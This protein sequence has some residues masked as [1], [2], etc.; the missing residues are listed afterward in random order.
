MS[1]ALC[2][3]GSVCL[4]LF[5]SVVLCGCGSV[6]VSLCVCGSMALCV[7]FYV[8]VVL[9]VRERIYVYMEAGRVSP[10]ACV[11]VCMWIKRV[12]IRMFV[13]ACECA[14]CVRT[15]VRTCVRVC[16]VCVLIMWYF[17]NTPPPPPILSPSKS[18]YRDYQCLRNAEVSANAFTT[19]SARP[20]L[21][22]SVSVT[23]GTTRRAVSVSRN[24]TSTRSK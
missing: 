1:V 22:A 18:V 11:C 12:C 19:P 14:A 15:Y 7:W 5:V 6:C 17:F 8:S 4:W 20:G 13:R 10:L 24:T 2:V 16:V 3:C 9:C 23:S 21:V